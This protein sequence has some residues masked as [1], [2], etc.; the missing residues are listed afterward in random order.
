[1]L[2]VSLRREFCVKKLENQPALHR[3]RVAYNATGALRA[4]YSSSTRVVPGSRMMAAPV[5]TRK[6][7]SR[8]FA[9]E[10][11]RQ[12]RFVSLGK[13]SNRPQEQSHKSQHPILVLQS[14]LGNQAVLRMLQR[15]LPVGPTGDANEQQA[16]RFATAVMRMPNAEAHHAANE[17]GIRLSPVSS[18]GPCLATAPLAPLSVHEVLRSPGRPL[19]SS[20]PWLH[21][22]TFQ[23]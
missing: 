18:S 16:D 5:P 23:T 6:V 1:M 8:M 21:G 3:G 12:R 17:H 19:D 2:H 13:I 22:A 4:R 20:V 11:Q 7:S 15:R 10:P 14:S 9:R